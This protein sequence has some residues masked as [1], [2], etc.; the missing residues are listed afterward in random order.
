MAAHQHAKGTRFTI[1]P[2]NGTET[3][4]IFFDNDDWHD[5]KITQ[6]NPPLVIPAGEGFE[7][8]CTWFNDT[9]EEK[10]YGLYS[11]DE[12]CNMAV[13]F[14]PFDVNAACEVVET[15]DGVLWE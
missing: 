8:A 13:V 10:N 7:F 3:G 2:W 6:Y 15:S 4:E 1:A 14:T 12:M 9:A 5:P 11:T